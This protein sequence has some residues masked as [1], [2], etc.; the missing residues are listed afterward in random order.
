M[1]WDEASIVAD[2]VKGQLAT[3][4]VLIQAATATTG[5]AASQKTHEHFQ[6][7]IKQLSGEN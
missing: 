5:W 7:L 3:Q 1:V 2:R 4:A 6:G